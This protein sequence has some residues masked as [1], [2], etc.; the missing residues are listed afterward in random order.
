MAFL[1]SAVP[2]FAGAIQVSFDENGNGTYQDT[3]TPSQN[4]YSATSGAVSYL[5]ETDPTGTVGGRVLVYELPELVRSGSVDVGEPGDTIGL[6]DPNPAAVI[7]FTNSSGTNDGG[8]DANLLIFYT[9][10]G[11]ASLADT[12]LPATAGSNFDVVDLTAVNTFQWLPDGGNTYPNG[13]QYDGSLAPEPGSLSPEPGS[14]S[15]M[16]AGA[17]ALALGAVR[18]RTTARG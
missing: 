1:M 13:N 12:G 15:T 4:G 3:Q 14:L 16:L 18:R 6:D 17:A 8:L 11:T 10:D 7:D 2:A 9:N 5:Y